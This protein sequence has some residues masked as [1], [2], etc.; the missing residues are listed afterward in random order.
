[1]VYEGC[2]SLSCGWSAAWA[3]ELTF[4]LPSSLFLPFLQR[5]AVRD[6]VSLRHVFV[7]GVK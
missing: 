7:V 2:F 1:M 3:A 6:S 5:A 4:S